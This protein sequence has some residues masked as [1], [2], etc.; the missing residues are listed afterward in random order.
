M[1]GLLHWKKAKVEM[2]N[3]AAHHF[4]VFMPREVKVGLPY[5]L[6]SF[7]VASLEFKHILLSS[8]R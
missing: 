4:S 3:F 2:K 5:P 7:G 6:T 1:F 8:N